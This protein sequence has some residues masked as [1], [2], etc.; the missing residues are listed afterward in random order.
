M[1]YKILHLNTDVLVSM[2]LL[3]FRHCKRSEA[4]QNFY[5]IATSPSAPRNDG[6]AN[7]IR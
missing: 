5:W 4:I 3:C 2:S 7:L 1:I 6:K